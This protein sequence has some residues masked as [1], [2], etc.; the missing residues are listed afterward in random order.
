MKE[1]VISSTILVIIALIT[2]GI[3][4]PVLAILWTIISVIG[5]KEIYRIQKIEKRMLGVIGYAGA[6]IY[7]ILIYTNHHEYTMMMI[8]ALLALFMIEYVFTFPKYNANQVVMAFFGFFYVAVML[9]YVYQIRVLENGIV[10]VWLIFIS[11]WIC[12]TSAYFVGIKFGKH[13]LAPVLSPKKSI[14]GAVGGMLGSA[15]FGAV[16]GYCIHR[17]AGIDI[18]PIVIALICMAGSMISMIGDLVA[19][20]IKRD[21][22]VKDY[23]D[24]IPGHGGI[25]DRFDS[26]LFTAPIIFY[27]TY[28]FM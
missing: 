19:S 28:Y 8:L 2:V 26:L 23:G 3:G 17:F 13:R 11:S 15:V 16:Y 27:L 24:L 6:I 1:R 10:F 25:L 4:G 22:G 18:N 5:M 14:E 9:S 12:D 7:Y 20:G 21:N